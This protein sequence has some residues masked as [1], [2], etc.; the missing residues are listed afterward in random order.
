MLRSTDRRDFLRHSAFLGA[1][2]FAGNSLL[3][4]ESDSP[5]EKLDIGIIGPGG[6]GAGNLAGVSSQNIVAITDVDDRRAAQ[7]Y[8]EYPDA[9]KYKDFRKML[10]DQKLDAVVVSTPDHTHAYCSVTAMRRG[11]HCYCEKPLTRTVWE[12]RLVSQTA[13]EYHVATQMGTQIHAGNN[14]RRVV[15]IIRSGAIGPV[16]EVKVWVGKGWG[17]V[18]W[19]TDGQPVPP[20]VDWDTWL[21]PAAY[22]PYNDAFMPA[23]WRRWW[24]FGGGTLGDMGCHYIDLVFWALEL[25]HPLTCEAEG[26]PPHPE[27]AP[28]G[29]KVHWEYP[30]RGDQPP[31]KLTWTDGDRAESKHDGHELGGSGVYFIGDEGTMFADYGSYKLFPEEKFADF[32]P[33]EPTIPDSIGH[34]NEWI[35]ACK[36]G[37]PTTCNFDYSGALTES[38]LLGNVAYRIG[39][40]VEW[41]AVNLTA[42]NA[43]EAANIVRQFSRK[44]WEL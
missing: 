27:T 7:A 11:L 12:A 28:S 25:R 39:K 34:H 20:E 1:G 15:E 3:A 33:P 21:G 16:K 10:D 8:S 14:Y 38:V 44:G 23:Q 5:N 42:T 19:P 9:A 13:K 18:E 41:D 32:K 30:A 35:Q 29:L 43:P 6:R 26:P 37:S 22:R 31:V 24:D 4:Q 36:T 2:L 40:K 17:G